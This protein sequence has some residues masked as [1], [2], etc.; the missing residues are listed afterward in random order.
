MEPPRRSGVIGP[1]VGVRL[2]PAGPDH[3]PS[4][5]DVDAAVL[6]EEEDVVALVDS[7]QVLDLLEERDLP[8]GT[9]LG[10]GDRQTRG[11]SQCY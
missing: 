3:E 4:D 10:A 1:S 6:S 7:E 5:L 11:D 8:S 9:V 2:R